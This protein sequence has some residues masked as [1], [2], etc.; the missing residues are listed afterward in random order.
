MGAIDIQDSMVTPDA[1]VLVVDDSRVVRMVVK[2]YLRSTGYAVDEAGDGIAALRLLE[3]A[4]YDVVVSDIMMPGIDGFALLEALGQRQ[5][6]PEVILLTG[7]EGADIDSESRAWR[8]GAHGFLTKPPSG[9]DTLVLAV[10][11]A[12][13]ARR[14]RAQR[15]SASPC[16]NATISS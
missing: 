16:V 6:R 2:S 5:D 11:R 3:A 15:A 14:R 4:P 12:L 1:R 7:A 8:L 13:A 10:Q 9:P